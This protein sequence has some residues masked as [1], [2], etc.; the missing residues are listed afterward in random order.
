MVMTQQTIQKIIVV[1]NSQRIT[2]GATARKGVSGGVSQCQSVL[3]SE[4]GCRTTRRSQ[5]SLSTE[6]YARETILRNHCGGSMEY[7]RGACQTC[8]AR[9]AVFGVREKETPRILGRCVLCRAN[10]RMMVRTETWITSSM[11]SFTISFTPEGDLHFG[12]A[13]RK[14]FCWYRCRARGRSVRR[15]SAGLDFSERTLP[16]VPREYSGRWQ[17]E[18]KSIL[19]EHLLPTRTT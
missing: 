10:L 2:F 3:A 7:A 15:A 9:L 1:A 11:T 13:F 6:R 14:I 16:V 18:E 4:K 17:R 19:T 12:W 8:T 5:D